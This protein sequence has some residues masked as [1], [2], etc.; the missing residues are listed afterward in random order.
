[1]QAS[2]PDTVVPLNPVVSGFSSFES[3]FSISMNGRGSFDAEMSCVALVESL[4]QAVHR[5]AVDEMK[6][7]P[8]NLRTLL[9]IP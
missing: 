1:M 6:R 2:Y 5:N 8:K 7:F 4:S 3:S 9:F